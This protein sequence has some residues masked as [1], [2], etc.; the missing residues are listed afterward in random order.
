MARIAQADIKD[1]NAGVRP[2]RPVFEGE[3]KIFQG[4]TTCTN[5]AMR[6]STRYQ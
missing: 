2:A 4:Q 5:V 1:A 3:R 6:R